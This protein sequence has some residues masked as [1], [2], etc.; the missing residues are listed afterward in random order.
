LNASII[1]DMSYTD[2]TAKGGKT[3]FYAVTAVDNQ[4]VESDFSNEVVADVP[5]N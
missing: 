4:N 5:K 1:D 3:Y 2:T